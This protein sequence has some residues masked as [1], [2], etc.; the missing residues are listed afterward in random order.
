MRTQLFKDMQVLKNNN[1]LQYFPQ[2]M[3]E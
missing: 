1:I 2:S 3:N